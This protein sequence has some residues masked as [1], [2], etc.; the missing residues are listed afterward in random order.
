[1]GLFKPVWPFEFFVSN[2]EKPKMNHKEKPPE[3]IQNNK[4]IN[5]QKLSKN[6]I[7]FK[8]YRKL[9]TWCAIQSAENNGMEFAKLV[10]ILVG[11]RRPIMMRYAMTHH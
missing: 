6:T 10:E 4:T 11:E 5:Q 3:I 2:E 1:M 9:S 8:V 7:L